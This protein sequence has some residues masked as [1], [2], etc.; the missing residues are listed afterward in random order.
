MG[1]VR[2]QENLGLLSTYWWMKPDPGA[3][4]SLLVDR[5]KSWGLLA[6][7]R[8]PR[9]NVRLLTVGAGVLKLVLAYYWVETRPSQFQG[10]PGPQIVMVFFLSSACLL[11]GWVGSETRA[12][13][14]MDGTWAGVSACR[15]LGV[16]DL[17]P[18]YWYV[19]LGPGS[20][21]GQGYVQRWLQT[22]GSWGNLSAGRWGCV[23][24]QLTAWPEASQYLCLQTVGLQWDFSVVISCK[25]NSRIVLPCCR[26]SSPKWFRNLCPQGE[27]ELFPTSPGGGRSNPGYYQ[28]TA[29][30][31]GRLCVSPLQVRSLFPSA[32]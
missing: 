19:G 28:I 15:V 12:G 4:T 8:G 22:Q 29:S 6:G 14:L 18:V 20:S 31:L 10:S 1:R 30:T 25:K 23:S 9:A 26:R 24:V 2:I 13:S 17:L 7:P 3:T 27:M 11:V 21:G 16:L 5:A 32:F